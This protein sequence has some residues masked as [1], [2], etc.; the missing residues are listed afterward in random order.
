[1][2]VK[3]K[4]KEEKIKWLYEWTEKNWGWSKWSNLIKK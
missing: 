4:L 2:Q 3:N 1:M